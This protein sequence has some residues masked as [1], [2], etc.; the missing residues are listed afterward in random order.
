MD[1]L[2]QYFEDSIWYYDLGKKNAGLKL[3]VEFNKVLELKDLGEQFQNL[4]AD[5][6][7]GGVNRIAFL[8]GPVRR[9]RRAV[10]RELAGDLE[11]FDLQKI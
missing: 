7:K 1:L 9:V 6:L 5:T 11:T 8:M 2:N 3:S 10:Y 4:F